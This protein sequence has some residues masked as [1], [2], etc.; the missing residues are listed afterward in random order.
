LRVDPE[1]VREAVGPE[2]AGLVE[3][4]PGPGEADLAEALV[5]VDEAVRL[6][7]LAEH[8]DH[9]RHLHLRAPA[10]DWSERLREVEA[11]WIPV[12]ERT[13]TEL[14]RRYRHWA[15]VFRRRLE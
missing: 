15:K 5:T 10:P 4:A 2:V 3:A 13:R 12:A 14:S 9:L 6:M 11:V 7:A 1:A 8:P